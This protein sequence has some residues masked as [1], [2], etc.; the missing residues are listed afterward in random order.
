M[1]AA[2]ALTK[3]KQSPLYNDYNDDI[4]L[5]ESSVYSQSLRANAMTQEHSPFR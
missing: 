2:A 1:K 5:N 4:Y 3:I